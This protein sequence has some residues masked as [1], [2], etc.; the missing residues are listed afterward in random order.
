VSAISPAKRTH[1]IDASQAA[2]PLLGAESDAAIG[3]T[4]APG[5]RLRPGKPPADRKPGTGTDMHPP[6]RHHYETRP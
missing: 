6:H 2:I 1:R 3:L 4:K 5:P